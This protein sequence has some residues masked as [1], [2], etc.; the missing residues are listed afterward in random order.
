MMFAA[1]MRVSRKAGVRLPPP[2]NAERGGYYSGWVPDLIRAAE[3]DPN[4]PGTSDARY[5]AFLGI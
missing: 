4:A 2:P 1:R 3:A 5:R